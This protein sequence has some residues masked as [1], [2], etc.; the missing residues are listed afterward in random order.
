METEQ[1]NY[2]VARMAGLLGVDRRR[3]YEWQAAKEAPPTPRAARMDTLVDAV[4][5]LHAASDKT[6]GAPRIRADL[7]AEGWQVSEKTVAKAMRQAQIQGISPRTW[8]PTTTIQ[9]AQAYPI[10]DRVKRCFDMGG[11]DLAWFSDIVRREALVFHEEVRDLVCL[12][13][14]ATG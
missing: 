6:Y 1:A 5:R 12:V 13:V 4:S 7:A 10:P 9:G 11:K 8:H 3:F 14:V 2:P